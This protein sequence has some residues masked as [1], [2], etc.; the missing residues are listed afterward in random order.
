MKT[1]IIS[2]KHEDGSLFERQEYFGYCPQEDEYVI[3]VFCVECGV[4][5]TT[6]IF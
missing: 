5:F 2:Q 6:R 3:E 4:R 1:M